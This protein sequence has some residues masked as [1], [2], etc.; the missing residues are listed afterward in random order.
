MFEFE[1]GHQCCNASLFLAV[2]ILICLSPTSRHAQVTAGGAGTS[3]L[4]ETPEPDKGDFQ[5]RPV[6]TDSPRQTLTTILRLRDNLEQTILTA[7]DVKRRALHERVRLLE[8]QFSALL[9]LSSV[10]RGSRRK[11]G[12]ETI[13]FLLDILGR[14]D[15]PPMESVPDA[16]AF[17]DEETPGKW[18]IPRT[19]ITIVRIEEGP[20]EGEFLFGART[21]AIAPGVYPQIQHLAVVRA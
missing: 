4:A 21:I 16:D 9:G 2:F 6:R 7:R 3:S 18:R 20:R 8:E 1:T 5:F 15:L 11:I 12:S 13:A 17:D 10:P 19:P 14:L